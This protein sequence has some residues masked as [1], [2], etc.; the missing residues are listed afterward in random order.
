MSRSPITCRF[1]SGHA[2]GGPGR[3]V[4]AI[5]FSLVLLLNSLTV[6]TAFGHTGS[7]SSFIVEICAN[8]HVSE[9]VVTGETPPPSDNCPR[10][11]CVLCLPAL[12]PDNADNR[13]IAV[14][15]LTAGCDVAPV[16]LATFVPRKVQERAGNPR[17][18]P[19]GV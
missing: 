14:A 2:H 10:Q 9:V 16:P 4:A 18:P 6:A 1:S 3:G 15:D 7:T 17:A 19:S 5:V 11:C 12:I 8:G 13:A